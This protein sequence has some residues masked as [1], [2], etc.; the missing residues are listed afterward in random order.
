MLVAMMCCAKMA[1]RIKMQFGGMTFVGLRNHELHGVK[2]STWERA[3]L[4]GCVG[5][6]QHWESL[7]Q[8]T[9][10]IIIQSSITAQQQCIQLSVSHY[11]VPHETICPLQCRLSSTHTTISTKQK[12]SNRSEPLLLHCGLNRVP[13]SFIY[14]R[15]SSGKT[16]Y[17]H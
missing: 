7:L 16:I 12:S 4:Q 2:I 13:V 10:Q 3:I 14:R 6:G 17:D 8:C 11:I 15:R 1:K 5:L 9:Q